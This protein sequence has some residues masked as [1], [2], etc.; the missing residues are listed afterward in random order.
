MRRSITPW[1]ILVLAIGTA[2]IAAN[3]RTA[4]GVAPVRPERTFDLQSATMADIQAAMDA[5]AL[6]SEGLTQ[7]YLARIAAYDKQGPTINAFITLNPKALESARALDVERRATGP[8]SPVHDV[9]VVLKDLFDTADMPTT[10]GF[11]PMASSQ[12]LVVCVALTV[13]G[14]AG[15]PTWTSP[16]CR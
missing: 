9:P 11:L 13:R 14:V 6:T 12:P 10:A 16:G 1:L 15:P 8:R 3:S 4:R 5:G 7:L 2:L